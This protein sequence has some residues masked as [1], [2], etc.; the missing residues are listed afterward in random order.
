MDIYNFIITNRELILLIY[1][2]II[3]IICLAIV[4]KTDK[5]FRLSLHQG[6]R[7]FRNAFFFYGLA[8]ILRYFLATADINILIIRAVFEFFVVIAGFS[9]LYSLLWKRLDYPQ[10][11]FSSIFNP[12]MGIFYLFSLIIIILDCLW[13]NYYFMFFSQILLFAIAS[14][15]SGAGYSK[16]EKRQGFFKLYF[17]IILLNFAAWVFNFAVAAIFNWSQ[18]GVINIYILNLIIFMLFLYIVQKATK[19]N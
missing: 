17:I 11:S 10:K 18:I 7:Y 8:F 4:L 3:S 15:V 19:T 13:G 1:T 9:L 12:K 14:I 5:L 6:I 16:A 2:I